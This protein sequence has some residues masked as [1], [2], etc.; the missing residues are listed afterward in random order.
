MRLKTMSLMAIRNKLKWTIYASSRQ[1][2]L[3]MVSEPVIKQCA[4]EDVES[5]RGGGL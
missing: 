3:Q 2:L 4:N 1:G 5:P